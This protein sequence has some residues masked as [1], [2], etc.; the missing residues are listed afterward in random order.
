M[1]GVSAVLILGFLAMTGCASGP[2]LLKGTW[3]KTDDA[4]GRAFDEQVR[5]RFPVGSPE[6]DLLAELKRE[7][8]KVEPVGADPRAPRNRWAHRERV[9]MPLVCGQDWGVFWQAEG[10]RIT[11]VSGSTYATCL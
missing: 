6:D 11:Q 2:S 1:R 4:S 7:H 9:L 3:G 8:F 10:G 5:A